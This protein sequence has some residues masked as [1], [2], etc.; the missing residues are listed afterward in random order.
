MIIRWMLLDYY[1]L[2]AKLL[3]FEIQKS[4]QI[5]CALKPYFLMPGHIYRYSDWVSYRDTVLHEYQ[6][7]EVAV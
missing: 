2:S 1:F 3:K 7:I 6:S 5:L 4:G